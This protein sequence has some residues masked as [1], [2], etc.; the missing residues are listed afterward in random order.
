MALRFMVCLII[1]CRMRVTLN[2]LFIT[3]SANLLQS[4]RLCMANRILV[5]C[6]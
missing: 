3:K 2:I 4:V 6:T 1:F 5:F